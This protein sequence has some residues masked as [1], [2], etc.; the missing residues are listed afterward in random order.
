MTQTINVADQTMPA[1]GLGLWKI[2]P[3]AVAQAVYDAIKAGYRHL[4]SA[5]D[6]GNEV[7]IK[8]KDSYHTFKERIATGLKGIE[9]AK[10]YKKMDE[11]IAE[12]NW[13]AKKLGMQ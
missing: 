12:S 2:D 3:G 5:A 13:L 4:D 6:Y 8:E 1:V 9:D 11:D 10:T 7:E